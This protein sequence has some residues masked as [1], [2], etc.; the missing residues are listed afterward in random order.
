MPKIL[1]ASSKKACAVGASS[2]DDLLIA[3]CLYDVYTTEI[4]GLPKIDSFYLV[5]FL[6]SIRGVQPVS[7]IVSETI[8]CGHQFPLAELVLPKAQRSRNVQLLRKTQPGI[9]NV[10]SVEH[11]LIN[12]HGES[13]FKQKMPFQKHVDHLINGRHLACE[14]FD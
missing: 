2:E 11:M 14:S 12:Y 6:S 8:D 5:K 1:G 9:R 13:L 4:C 10:L 7:K 3:L